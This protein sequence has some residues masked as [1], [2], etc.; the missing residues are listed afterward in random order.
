MKKML[1][2]LLLLSGIVHPLEYSTLEM[3]VLD[4]NGNPVPGVEFFLDCKM[5]FTTVERHI[6]T[7]GPNGTCK[8][9]CMDCAPG[10]AAFVR[11]TY[12]NQTVEQEIISWTGS[13][14]ESCQPSHPSSNPLGNFIVYVEGP[15]EEE[16]EE[17]ASGEGAS[18]NLPENVNIETKDYHLSTGEDEEYTYVS[19]VNDSGNMED[20][21]N[22]EE[23]CL[24]VFAILFPLAWCFV[25]RASFLF[26]N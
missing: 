18:K 13:D 1:F 2:A 4:Q 14:A 20:S 19:Y 21:E 15:P 10:E 26:N 12:S 24:P 17:E 6:C 22:K 7:S 3:K 9:A 11:A 16:P 5:T 25:S 23:G 8:S